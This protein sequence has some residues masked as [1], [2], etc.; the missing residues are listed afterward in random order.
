MR[1]LLPQDFGFKG[2]CRNMFASIFYCLW[3]WFC[4]SLLFL[5]FSTRNFQLGKVRLVLTEWGNKESESPTHSGLTV[6]T[7]YFS[8][9]WSPGQAMMNAVGAPSF[10]Q[11][12]GRVRDMKMQRDTGGQ[13]DALQS[14]SYR[15]L[16]LFDCLGASTTVQKKV[17]FAC[18]TAVVRSG[19]STNSRYTQ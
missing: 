14:K 12:S 16:R 8:Q 1:K 10:M 15:C 19:Q 13:P 9:E 6:R 3:V 17:E 5:F 4:F 18:Y 2:W 11:E 7:Q